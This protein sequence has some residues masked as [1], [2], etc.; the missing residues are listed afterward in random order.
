[1]RVVRGH[2]A[3][4]VRDVKLEV[5]CILRLPNLN[6]SGSILLVSSVSEGV[7]ECSMQIPI[8]DWII[9]IFLFLGGM[10]VHVI[11]KLGIIY[12][13]YSLGSRIVIYLYKSY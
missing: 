1:M 10:K 2:Y 3:S 7:C 5:E 12:H 13:L 11:F 8:I 9:H 4:I 6:H